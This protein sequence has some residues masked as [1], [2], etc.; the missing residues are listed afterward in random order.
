[1]AHASVELIELRKQFETEVTERVAMEGL[2]KH[3]CQASLATAVGM[4]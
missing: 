1:M 3:M 2:L 4:R